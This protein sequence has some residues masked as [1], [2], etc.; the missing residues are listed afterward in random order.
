M[1]LRREIKFGIW[2]AAAVAL[3][4]GGFFVG[5]QLK[6]EEAPHYILD[7]SAPAYGAD[8]DAIGAKSPGGF[9]GFEDIVPDG[10]RTVLGG[11]IV[12]LTD[13][14]MTLE[15]PDGAE[16][17]MRLGPEPKLTRLESGGR[18]LLQPGA[19]VLVKIGDTEADAAAV[20]VISP[21]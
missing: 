19:S 7:V 15:T 6:P 1:R 13:A 17:Q 3:A 10:S 20:L 16:T 9:T 21:P 8:V 2:M 14:G 5:G 4:I 12:D 11:R 18:D